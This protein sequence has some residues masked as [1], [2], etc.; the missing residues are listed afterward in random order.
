[1]TGASLAMAR[2]RGERGV[3]GGIEALPFGLLIFV[4]GALLLANV[5]GVVDAKLAVEDAARQAGRAYAESSP[6]SASGAAD[7]AARQ[8]IAGAGRNPARLTIAARRPPFRR[9]AVVEHET[10]YQV[11]AIR[12]PFIGGFGRGFTVHGRHRDVIDPFRSGIE[13]DGAC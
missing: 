6:E 11:P 8:A 1:M 3:V 5:W 2:G 13:G 9:C 7:R 4:C 10:S 12:L